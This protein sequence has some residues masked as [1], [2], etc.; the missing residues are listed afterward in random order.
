MTLTETIALL[1]LLGGAVFVTF[2]ISWAIFKEIH[3]NKN[4]R[5]SLPSKAVILIV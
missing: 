1:G 4:D 3:N 5:P 2:Q